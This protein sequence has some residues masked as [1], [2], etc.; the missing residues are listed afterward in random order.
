M[1]AGRPTDLT[2]EVLAGIKQATLDGKTLKDFAEE[3]GIP[4][5]TIYSW[6]SDNY[7]S[8]ADKVANWKRD[9]MLMLAEKNIVKIL[10]TTPQDAIDRK[11][12]ADMNKFAAKTLGKS[13]YSERQEMTGAEGEKLNMGVVILPALDGDD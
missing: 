7:L 2:K 6:S 11:I 13:H 5:S 9:R 8:L 4:E 1:P 12:Q 10:S 3:S